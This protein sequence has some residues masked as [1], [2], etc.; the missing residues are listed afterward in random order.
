MIRAA[1][2]LVTAAALALPLPAFAE[3]T[4]TV[5]RERQQRAVPIPTQLSPAQRAAYRAIFEDLAVGNWAGAVGRM[6]ELREG[7]LHDVVRAQLYTMPGSPRVELE[8]LL[9]LLAKAPEL[10]Q[11]ESLARLAGVRGAVQV[12]ELPTIQRLVGLRGQP[13]RERPRP[14]RTE[15]LAGELDALIQPLIRAD[16]PAEAEALLIDRGAGLSPEALAEFQQR[17]A[18]SYYI[19]GQDREALRL[20]GLSKGA[21][22]DWAL[23]SEWISG[24]A[25]WR[26]ADCEAAEA[27]FLTVARRSD[28][29]ELAAA[30][31]YWASRA[32]T[33][34]G[35]PERVQGHLRAAAGQE[36]TFYGLLAESAL[37]L[38][39]QPAGEAPVLTARDWAALSA[40][41]NVRT[42]VA[43]LEAGQV[44]LAD[45]M[46]RHQARIGPPAEHAALTR[47]AA[48]LDLAATQMFL[49]HNGPRGVQLSRHDRY[50]APDWQPASAQ[51]RV[52]QALAYA[53]ALQESNFRP[54]AV[55]QAGARGLMQVRPGTAGDL[56]RW[57]RATADPSRLNDPSTNLAFGQANLE[58]LR[59]QPGTQGLLLRVIAA[60]SAGPVPIAR[61]TEQG[62]GG[63]D[64]LLYIES[65][66][67]WETR[68]YVPIILRNYWMYEHRPA[69]QSL[70]R[71]ALVQGMWPRFPGSEG[72]PAVRLPPAEVAQ[73]R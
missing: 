60:Y 14:V 9:A 28:D 30:G 42:A 6:D 32:A 31:H 10:P 47:L 13:R 29:S 53:H 71:R 59:D 24:L 41:P 16:Q 66:P 57:G 44:E 49:A 61:W 26:L 72:A 35:H 8:P 39:H 55:S 7:P 18:W 54:N 62:V 48:R 56:I 5:V 17:I 37:G 23:Q 64:P 50:P 25:S 15:P 12:P 4:E 69:D 22:G 19:V 46:I 68:G 20:A 3:A 63:G 40:R 11:A 70:T 67:Y 21:P 38:R 33:R 1:T 65:L 73:N 34:C 2:L 45:T 51:W 43:L 58:Y 52:D 27:S 36:E